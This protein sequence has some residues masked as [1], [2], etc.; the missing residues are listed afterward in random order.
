MKTIAEFKAVLGIV[1]PL[2]EDDGAI[3]W[4]GFEGP[5][6]AYARDG[7]DAG[8]ADSPGLQAMLD[9]QINQVKGIALTGRE[10]AEVAAEIEA[11]GAADMASVNA[12][13]DVFYDA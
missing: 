13:L 7:E 11:D 8:T 2:L 3:L 6:L 12:A 9:E 10:R 4:D 5:T 1:N